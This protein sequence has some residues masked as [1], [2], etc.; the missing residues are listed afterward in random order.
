MKTNKNINIYTFRKIF[1]NELKKINRF[2]NPSIMAGYDNAVDFFMN[3]FLPLQYDFCKEFFNYYYN[4]NFE[5]SQKI[6]DN[7]SI[8]EIYSITEEEMAAFAFTITYFE[9]FNAYY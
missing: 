2:K 6:D 4:D 5:I 7:G 1:E 3:D 9:D 8:I